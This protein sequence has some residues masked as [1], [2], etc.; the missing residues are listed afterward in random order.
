MCPAGERREKP[1]GRSE[2]KSVTIV[3]ACQILP[4]TGSD[5]APPVVRMATEGERKTKVVGYLIC[6]AVVVI[7][8]CGFPVHEKTEES[9]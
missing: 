6:G 4:E 7:G 2:S 3:E 5:E 1:T 9:Q 8:L